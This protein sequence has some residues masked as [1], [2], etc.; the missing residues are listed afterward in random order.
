MSEDDTLP[1]MEITMVSSKMLIS[2]M[3]TFFSNWKRQCLFRSKILRKFRLCFY[4]TPSRLVINSEIVSL[5]QRTNSD[6]KQNSIIECWYFWKKKFGMHFF[7]ILSVIVGVIA[8]F[9]WFFSFKYSERGIFLKQISNC[10]CHKIRF[11][12]AFNGFL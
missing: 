7:G 11:L 10:V 9:F 12:F 8:I 6:L 3:I 2:F 1:G 5:T 4:R